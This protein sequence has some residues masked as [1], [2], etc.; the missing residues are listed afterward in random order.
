[1]WIVGV[2]RNIKTNSRFF[3]VINYDKVFGMFINR[4][5]L[6]KL[7]AILNHLLLIIFVNCEFSVV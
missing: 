2:E 1:M 6:E 4:R 5:K 3:N 7:W